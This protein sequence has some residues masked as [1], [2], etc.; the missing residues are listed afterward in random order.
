MATRI[1]AVIGQLVTGAQSLFNGSGPTSA[2]QS[3]HNINRFLSTVNNAGGF[4]RPQKYRVVIAFQKLL[5]NFPSI[6][7]QYG[8]SDIRTVD[9]LAFLCDRAEIPAKVFN[10]TQVRT[11]GPIYSLPYNAGYPDVTLEFYVGQ[12]ML[13]KKFFDAWQYCIEDPQTFD[14]AYP[15]MYTTQIAISQFTEYGPSNR[16]GLGFLGDLAT[17]IPNGAGTL[18]SNFLPRAAPVGGEEENPSHEVILFNAWPSAVNAMALDY[19]A[20]DEF[21]KIQVRMSYKRWVAT[22]ITSGLDIPSEVIGNATVVDASGFNT[23]T[24]Q[25]TSQVTNP[26]TTNLP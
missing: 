4:A 23:F 11:Y 6:F 26:G 21:H 13:E 19:N 12:D 5:T 15:D 22:D 17:L 2:L 7:N 10:T 18:L 3:N 8:I 20:Q 25:K 9:R 16:Q 24:P 1:N 14:I